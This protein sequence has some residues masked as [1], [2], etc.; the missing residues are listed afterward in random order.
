MNALSNLN[1]YLKDLEYST[2]ELLDNMEKSG[3]LLHH[4]L[5]YKIKSVLEQ[6]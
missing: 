4:D 6:I 3:D 5:N 1:Q 2:T